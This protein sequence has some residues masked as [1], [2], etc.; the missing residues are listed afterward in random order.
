[1]TK[2]NQN[3]ENLKSI[4]GGCKE[5]NPFIEKLKKGDKGIITFGTSDFETFIVDGTHIPF[6]YSICTKYDKIWGYIDTNDISTENFI[7][8][9]DD[10]L[11]RYWEH[12]TQKFPKGIYLY[13]HNMSKFDGMLIFRMIKILIENKYI[14]HTD[15]NIISR[16]TNFY[17]I[18]ICEK[19]SFIDSVYILP[20]KLADIAKIYAEKDKGEI[21]YDFTIEIIKKDKDKIIEYCLNDSLILYES[22]K[23]FQEN[24]F[25][26]YKLDPL[27]SLTITAFVFRLIRYRYIEDDTIENTSLALNKSMF[28]KE[29]YQGGLSTVINPISEKYNINCIDINSSYPFAMTKEL[30]IGK[31]KWINYEENI[32]IDDIFGFVDVMLSVKSPHIISPLCLKYNRR[33]TEVNTEQ[34][35]VI[36]FSEEL[37]FILKHGGEIIKIYKILSYKKGFP[38]SQFANDFYEMKK[39]AKNKAEINIYKLILNSAYGRFG[40]RFGKMGAIIVNQD[41]K[42]IIEEITPSIN[43]YNIIKSYNTN[44]NK[45]DISICFVNDESI[46]YYTSSSI[47]D[48]RLK[49]FLTV[50]ENYTSRALQIA[51]AIT[52]YGRI[53]LLE[54]IINLSKENKIYYADTDSIYFAGNIKSAEDLIG[55]ELG[56]WGLEKYNHRGI[57][58]RSKLYYTEDKSLEQPNPVCKGLP[59]TVL[60]EEK[61]DTKLWDLFKGIYSGN[62]HTFIY[63]KVFNRK[64]KDLSVTVDD[65]RFTASIE[66]TDKRKKIFDSNNTWISTRSL[67]VLYDHRTRKFQ[68]PERLLIIKEENKILFS[69][70]SLSISK[71]ISENVKICNKKIRVNLLTYNQ[72]RILI[73]HIESY[74]MSKVLYRILMYNQK[75]YSFSVSTS[76]LSFTEILE[77][78]ADIEERYKNDHFDRISLIMIPSFKGL[79]INISPIFQYFATLYPP[80]SGL[81]LLKEKVSYLVRYIFDINESNYDKEIL[82]LSENITTIIQAEIIE[83]LSRNYY[84]YHEFKANRPALL[85][86]IIDKLLST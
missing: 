81:Y 27:K 40:L 20:G 38:L 26:K 69:K 15:V 80:I 72:V 33:L 74:N 67:D 13:L 31:G 8:K 19:F 68:T 35:R 25:R 66:G 43:E 75:N 36:L 12:I 79:S 63:K 1:M 30:P 54:T 82:K 39:N 44:D 50:N 59:R 56:E 71:K 28:I 16:E 29:S 5:F 32:K 37:K 21:D 17:R 42:K 70:V 46:D 73:N 18:S 22:L 55:D 65:V 85:R 83:M 60:K 77:E 34:A 45:D 76:F 11:V 49:N 3:R 84:N 51:S 7:T 10:L 57:F 47:K 64:I 52:S 41:E 61:Y 86:L 2:I 6:N 9:S 48:K 62:N 14:K 23:N 78:I 24:I 53:Y 58:L 4:K